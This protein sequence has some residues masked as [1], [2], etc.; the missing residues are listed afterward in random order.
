MAD[1]GTV[2][3]GF[4]NPWPAFKRE[5]WWWAKPTH[6]DKDTFPPDE[7]AGWCFDVEPMQ[8]V[9]VVENQL[10]GKDRFRVLVLGISASQHP[11]NFI[12]GPPIFADD[13]IRGLINKAPST[14]SNGYYAE[15]N[16]ILQYYER[17]KERKL[18]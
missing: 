10:L 5:G 14:D 4:R 8:P 16:Q 12:W 3:M 18:K 7:I 2:G 9:Q 15:K 17:L 1:L 11:T 13:E 6:W